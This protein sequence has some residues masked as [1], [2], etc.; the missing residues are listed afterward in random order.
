MV[1]HDE[2][3]V[4]EVEPVQ[5]V[6]G[7]LCIHYIF[8]DD[9]CSTLAVVGNAETN[10]TNG[11]VFA[12]EIEEFFYRNVVAKVLDEKNPVDLGRKLSA[13]HSRLKIDSN[14]KADGVSSSLMGSRALVWQQSA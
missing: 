8:I 1:E 4:L 7:H 14:A 11:A 5:L 2:I 9:I 13:I 6:A 12:E 3:A 10:L